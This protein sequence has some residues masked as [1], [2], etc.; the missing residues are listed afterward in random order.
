MLATFFG[1][2]LTL[3][4]LTTY[5]RKGSYYWDDYWG[6]YY[7][8]MWSREQSIFLLGLFVCVCWCA[9]NMFSSLASKSSRISALMLPAQQMEKYLSRFLILIII[10]PVLYFIGIFVI[11]FIRVTVLKFFIPSS[12]YI[13]LITIK[14]VFGETSEE[15]SILLSVLITLQSFFT[16]GSSIWPKRPL[17]STSL[18]LFIILTLYSIVS[19]LLLDRLFH[20]NYIYGDNIENMIRDSWFSNHKWII[21]ISLAT[22]VSVI[23]YI[24]AYYRLKEIEIIQRW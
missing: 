2:I 8:P 11:D 18:A 10:A 19:M 5:N 13:H 9:S 24:I 12:P 15:I 21:P 4:L 1:V 6:S 3:V 20:E 17:I 14:R 16:L 22:I 23:N 7:D